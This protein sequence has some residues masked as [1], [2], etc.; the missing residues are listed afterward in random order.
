MVEHGLREGLAGSM[1]AEIG[2]VTEGLHD[3]EI[4]LNG[5]ERGS[6]TLLFGENVTTSSGQYTVDTTHS[7]LGNL[8]FSQEDG[9]L[10]SW[11]SEKSSSVKDTTGSWDELSTTTMNGIGVE[12]NIHN[13]KSDTSHWLLGNWTFS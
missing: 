4:G 7:G 12:G 13:V 6:W 10:Q 1:R 11:F 8:N 2:I 3:W 9:F 5:E